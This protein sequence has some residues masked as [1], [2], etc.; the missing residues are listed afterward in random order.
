MSTGARP[1]EPCTSWV[2]AARVPEQHSPYL[3]TSSYQNCHC[4]H[5]FEI[6]MFCILLMAPLIIRA[7]QPTHIT[8]P[9][10]PACRTRSLHLPC[11]CPLYPPM[12]TLPSLCPPDLPQWTPLGCIPVVLPAPWPSRFR[13]A[14]SQ[15][16]WR[17]AEHTCSGP[18]C[19]Y[20]RGGA[21][22]S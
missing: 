21:T 11:M 5:P 12:Y 22:R 13:I 8:H 17:A 6:A 9:T 10:C 7:W 19:R 20:R 4:S 14:T 18:Q 15:R 16:P 2:Y 3:G 1:Q